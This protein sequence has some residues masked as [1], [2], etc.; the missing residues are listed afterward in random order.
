MSLKR[1]KT[2]TPNKV[3][4][5]KQVVNIKP[6]YVKKEINKT[7]ITKNDNRN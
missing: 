2:Y 6:F 1:F 4:N 5:T 3:F 7:K